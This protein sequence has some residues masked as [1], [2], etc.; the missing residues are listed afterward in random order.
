MSESNGPCEWTHSSHVAEQLSVSIVQYVLQR[1]TL[2]TA[3]LD[4]AKQYA[5]ALCGYLKSQCKVSQCYL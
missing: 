5:L 3:L 4:R 2:H 1:E